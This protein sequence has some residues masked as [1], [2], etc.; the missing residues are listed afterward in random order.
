MCVYVYGLCVC[1]KYPSHTHTNAYA[2]THRERERKRQRELYQY[3]SV[4]TPHAQG[5]RNSNS[6]AHTCTEAQWETESKR[7]VDA[8]TGGYRT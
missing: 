6:E 5:R 1:I 4:F 3:E 8:C 7:E 2:N